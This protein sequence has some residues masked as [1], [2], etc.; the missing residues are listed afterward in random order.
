MFGK[1]K[2]AA[3]LAQQTKDKTGLNNP[4]FGVK[5]S[6]ETL[7]KLRKMVYCYDATDDYKLLGV[8]STVECLRQFK[9]G[10]NTLL[11]RI[12]DGEIYKGKYLF[13]R[14]PR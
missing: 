1:A 5:K 6:E 10:S 2:S 4:M 11:K 14:V 3:F 8:Y 13:S 7:A 12:A 9:M